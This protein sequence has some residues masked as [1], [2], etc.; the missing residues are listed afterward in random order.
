MCVAEGCLFLFF[1]HFPL[2]QDLFVCLFVFNDRAFF[3]CTKRKK[4]KN[5]GD[6]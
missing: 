3:F 4:K 1:L 2:V 6:K 5:E